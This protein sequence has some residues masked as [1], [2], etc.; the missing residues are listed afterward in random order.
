MRFRVAMFGRTVIEIDGRVTRLPPTTTAVLIRLVLA[1]G[2]IVTVDELFR[3]VWLPRPGSV[4]REDRISVQKRIVELRKLLDPE[5][6]GE[7]SQILRT[8]RGRTSAYQLVLEQ[9]QVDVFRFRQLVERAHAADP[10][11]TLQL[12]GA[13][14]ELWRGR[15]LLDVEQHPF[16]QKAIRQLHLLRGSADRALLQ[17][18][19]AVGLLDKALDTGRTLLAEHPQDSELGDL[20]EQLR[21][22]ASV[23]PRSVLQHEF[24]TPRTRVTIL[25]GDLFSQEDAHLVVGFTDTFDTSTSQDVVINSSS[26]QGQLLR[27]RYG[28]DRLW[29]DRDLRAA[30]SQIPRSGTETRATKRRGK[31]TRYPIGTVA[32]LNQSGRRIFAVA[33]SRM[34]NDLIARSSLA[35]LREGLDRLWAAIHRHGQLGVVAMPLVGSGLSRIDFL[36]REELVKA[37]VGSFV[38]HSRTR[39]FCPELRIVIPP[40]EIGRIDVLDVADYVRG[41]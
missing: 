37:I 8:D 19:R 2:E 18:Y 25:S 39:L 16:A 20:V 27:R 28:G 10:A 26:I 17:A 33:Y 40:A 1:D 6:P 29:L 21:R 23:Q 7:T 36:K 24:H 11:T 3:D 12:L 9:D 41:L 35:D 15:P 30:L 32:V 34:G 5:R 31:L 22:Q 13:A 14:R 4:R 38:A